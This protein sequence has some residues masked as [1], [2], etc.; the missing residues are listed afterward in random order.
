MIPLLSL[1]LSLG[2]PEKKGE[3]IKGQSLLVHDQS[4]MV[5]FHF[6]CHTEAVSEH[7]LSLLLSARHAQ[8]PHRLLQ[9]TVWL[10]LPIG[11]FSFFFFFNTTRLYRC[12]VVDLNGFCHASRINPGMMIYYQ[13][14]TISCLTLSFWVKVT[15]A[16]S[17]AHTERSPHTVALVKTCEKKKKKKKKGQIISLHI[18]I[19]M[20]CP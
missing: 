18:Y 9:D 5:T 10:L 11:H 7:Q 4:R 2:S 13:I 1:S 8:D 16:V 14:I 19:H 20:G 3:K 17:H 6:S 15:P 12:T